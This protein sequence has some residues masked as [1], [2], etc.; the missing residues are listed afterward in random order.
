MPPSTSEHASGFLLCP[1][2]IGTQMEVKAKCR[3]MDRA[4]ASETPGVGPGCAASWETVV[5]K[6]SDLR[7]FSS[8]VK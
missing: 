7:L 5:E 6:S 3:V 1:E 8:K 2:Q 4:G